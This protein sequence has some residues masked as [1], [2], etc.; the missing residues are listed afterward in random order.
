MTGGLPVGAIFAVARPWSRQAIES[1]T[2]QRNNSGGT[3]FSCIRERGGKEN[4]KGCALASPALSY[5]FILF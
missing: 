4:G 3:S 2:A 5:G 1:R